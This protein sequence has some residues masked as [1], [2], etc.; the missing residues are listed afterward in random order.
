MAR[1]QVAWVADTPLAHLSGICQVVSEFAQITSFMRDS[2]QYPEPANAVS[3][4]LGLANFDVL[5]FV[6]PT[7][8]PVISLE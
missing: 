5:K 6:R 7:P 4:A 3:G 8:I 2:K 1:V